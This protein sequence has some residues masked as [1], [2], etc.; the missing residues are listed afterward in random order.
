MMVGFKGMVS[1]SC[2]SILFAQSIPR[3]HINKRNWLNY[4]RNIYLGGDMRKTAAHDSRFPLS[5]FFLGKQCPVAY[6]Y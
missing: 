2:C 5:I 6:F 1:A 4:V 3:K